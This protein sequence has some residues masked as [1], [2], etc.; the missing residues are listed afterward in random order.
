M[1]RI[2]NLLYN[3]KYT[4]TFHC[5]RIITKW[6]YEAGVSL[7][8]GSSVGV[9]EMGIPCRSDRTEGMLWTWVRVAWALL[10]GGATMDVGISG[11]GMLGESA[12]MSSG[13]MYSVSR[14]TNSEGEKNHS[15]VD[16]TL[17][18]QYNGNLIFLK[19][20]FCEM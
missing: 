4:T 10:L 2:I 14:A 3:N 19:L 13:S 18:H 9:R 7:T 11:G 17:Y 16:K 20:I 12:W 8:G 6:L 1:L 15:F 5:K